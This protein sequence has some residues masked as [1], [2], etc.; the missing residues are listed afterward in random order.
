MGPKS[1]YSMGYSFVYETVMIKSLDVLIEFMAF[2]SSNTD[3]VSM[4]V[5]LSIFIA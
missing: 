5:G 1:I 2:T 3:I 4:I